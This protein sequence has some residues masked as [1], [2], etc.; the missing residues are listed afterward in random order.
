G[1]L[2]AGGDHGPG[3]RGG[4]ASAG[5][6][7]GGAGMGGG[8][9]GGGRGQGGEDEE[10]TRASFLQEDDPEAIFGTDQI[11]APPVIGG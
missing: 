3:G 6:R 8:M 10:H 7:G 1:A 11:T 2:G 9:G 4:A 5:G